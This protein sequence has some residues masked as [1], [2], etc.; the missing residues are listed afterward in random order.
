MRER[1]QVAR[2]VRPVIEAL[3]GCARRPE[4]IRGLEAEH[5]AGRVVGVVMNV[6]TCGDESRVAATVAVIVGAHLHPHSRLGGQ[7]FQFHHDRGKMPVN[8]IRR[9]SRDLGDNRRIPLRKR[10]VNG[11]NNRCGRPQTGRI[12]PFRGNPGLQGNGGKE[13]EEERG[14]FYGGEMFWG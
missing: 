3:A 6:A 5:L 7:V 9:H 12:L 4:A 1:R 13:D 14:G 8:S 2:E 10:S 11:G